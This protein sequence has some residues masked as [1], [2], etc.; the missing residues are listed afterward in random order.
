LERGSFVKSLTR[1]CA[2]VLVTSVLCGGVAGQESSPD[3]FGPASADAPGGN[4]PTLPPE[5]GTLV[6][7]ADASSVDTSFLDL[8]IDQLRRTSVV[9]SFDE[10]VTSVSRQESTVGRSP[11]AVFVV[12]QEMIRRSGVR[13]IPDV[14]R[15]VPGLHVAQIDAEKWAITCRGFNDRFADKLLV[16]ID[17]RV[18]YSPIFS[19]VYWDVQDLLLEDIE[20]IEVIR[21]PGATV[22]G[23]NAVN[24]VIN[25]ITKR[26]ADTVGVYATG[27]GGTEEKGFAGARVGGCAWDGDMHWRLYG[28]WQ[29]LDNGF[30][31]EEPTYDQWRQ[32]R[33]GG[34]MDWTPT[35]CD[36]ITLQGDV[37]RHA[38]G[39]A[40]EPFGVLTPNERS[41]AWGG[42]ILGRWTRQ[43]DDTREWA[44]QVY[45][46]R[47]ARDSWLS[48]ERVDIFDVDYQ[49][50]YQPGNRHELIWGVGFRRYS[51]IQP[52]RSSPV[53]FSFVPEERDY[54]LYGGFIQ[55]Q[56]TLIDEK[57]F[58]TIGTKL[59]DN[60]F[61]GFEVQPSARILW[62]PQPSRAI[63]G[64][65]SRGVRTP[66]RVESDIR[67]PLGG[68]VVLSGNKSIRSEELIA[69]ELGYRSQPA[70]WFSWDLALFYNVYEKLITLTDTFP[71][72]YFNNNLRGDTYGFELTGTLDVTP[73]WRV[74]GYYSFL[75]MD[76]HPGAGSASDGSATEGSSPRN[77][78][79]LWSSWDLTDNL[80][81]DLVGRYVGNLPGQATP[82]Y[83]TIDLRLAREFANGL[84][85]AVVGR[86]LIDSPHKE[87]GGDVFSLQ[88]TEVQRSVY[89]QVS[90]RY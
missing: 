31:A 89:G 22:W 77:Q 9:P 88:F 45:W 73:N 34:R 7:G 71:T 32:G 28:K 86:N 52:P 42:N 23:A 4:E 49:Y 55:D 69:Y 15:L 63:W 20:R 37:Y 27:G 13:H 30:R 57:L 58:F 44:F 90:W 41:G 21:G 14:L 53:A 78:V 24:G 59:D 64:S 12:T 26:A 70:E 36:L 40:L 80:E 72:I 76:L 19:G 6:V 2:V 84:E 75:R 83:A 85:L 74:F 61:T 1:T 82:S 62:A 35:D 3:E 65:V 17:G 66:S 46:D 60:S 5:N 87:F 81:F 79:S 68:P 39:D 54:Y 67:I 18:V 25:I 16:Q 48:D 47:T 50:N 38:N 51:D 29:E 8:D 10:L 43:V 33:S 11:A 56:I